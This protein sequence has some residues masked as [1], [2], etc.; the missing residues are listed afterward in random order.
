MVGC[1]YRENRSTTVFTV[2]KEGDRAGGAVDLKINYIFNALP[3]R[4][5]WKDISSVITA[6]LASV[7]PFILSNF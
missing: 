7:F 4:G 6:V 2:Q 3:Q 1:F 5:M